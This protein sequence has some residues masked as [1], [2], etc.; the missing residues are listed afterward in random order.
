M[1]MAADYHTAIG[2]GPAIQLAVSGPKCHLCHA[3][4]KGQSESRAK[5][6]PVRGS[7]DD[8][9]ILLAP[10][11][12]PLK[13]FAPAGESRATARCPAPQLRGRERPPVPPPRG[14]VA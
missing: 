12:A 6:N 3:I 2:W 7:D 8:L 11:G 1:K 10:P 9:R 14:T 5:D 4:E 13:V